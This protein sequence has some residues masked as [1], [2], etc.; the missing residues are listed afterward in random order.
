MSQLTEISTFGW[1]GP[2][3]SGLS[4]ATFGWFI[5]DGDVISFVF[6]FAGGGIVGPE[7]GV[8]GP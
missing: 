7:F 8:A 2:N 4:I 6:A 1:F 3:A 5:E